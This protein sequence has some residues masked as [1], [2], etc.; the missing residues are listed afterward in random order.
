MALKFYESPFH[1][2]HDAEIAS[3]M[4]MKMDLSIM[5]TN[6][7]KEK[8]WTQ[9]EAAEK[10]GISQS[11]V[12]ELKNAKIELFTIDAMFDMLDA[13]GFRAKMSMPSLHQASI[14]ITEIE[15]AG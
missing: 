9:R 4:A 13:L 10:L 7:I 3:K 14:A 5:I 6:L 2:T 11:R 12:S 8:G 1:V 15:S